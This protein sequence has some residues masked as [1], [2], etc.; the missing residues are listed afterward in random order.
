MRSSLRQYRASHLL[1]AVAYVSTGHR[2]ASTCVAPYAVS[3][4]RRMA[5]AAVAPWGGTTCAAVFPSLCGSFLTS[6]RSIRYVSPG[7]RLARA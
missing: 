7:H 6:G 2:S 5:H 1:C 3:T 4:R